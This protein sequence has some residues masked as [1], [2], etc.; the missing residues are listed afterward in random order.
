MENPRIKHLRQ[1]IVFP[2]LSHKT[3]QKAGLTRKMP[4]H[5]LRPSFIAHV[6]DHGPDVRD[7]QELLGHQDIKTTL[8]FTHVT[9]QT[10]S[11]INSPLDSLKLG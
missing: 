4:P 3:A 2:Q 1:T 5:A 11:T 7:I 6:L 10:L 8:I 9:N